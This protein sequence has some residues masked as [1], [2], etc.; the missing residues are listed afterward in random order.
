V[1]EPDR[2]PS[3]PAGA[4][5]FEPPAGPTRAAV[6]RLAGPRR[7]ANELEQLLADPYPLA[8]MIAASALA[9]R[10]SRGAHRRRDFPLP[11]PNL[12]N[13]HAVI[14]AQGSLRFDRWM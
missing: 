4:W 14:D 11:D 2:G 9:R 5:R 8:G 12:N 13:S 3:P 7:Q 10:E 1:T 6:W